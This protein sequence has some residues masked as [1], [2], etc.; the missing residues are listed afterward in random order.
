MT[1]E[2]ITVLKDDTE[3]IDTLLSAINN[4]S[5]IV[6]SQDDLTSVIN[7]IN[8]DLETVT[9]VSETILEEDEIIPTQT[10]LNDTLPYSI[11]IYDTVKDTLI[12]LLSG[13]KFTKSNWMILLNKIMS[14]VS[15]VKKVD[16]KT[17]LVYDLLM[18]YLDNYTDLDDETIDFINAN[19]TFTC[20]Y[21]L[22]NAGKNKK[23]HNLNSKSRIKQYKLYKKDTD[24][25]INTLQIS[26][27]L[28]NKIK[29][30]IRNN[31]ITITTLQQNA[32]EII[33]LCSSFIDKFKHL[34]QQEKCSLISQAIEDVLESEI[35]P[36]IDTEAGK[37]T[38]ELVILNLP[39]LITTVVG[40]INGDIDFDLQN[41]KTFFQRI[42]KKCKK[43][44]SCCCGRK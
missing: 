23:E 40:V 24:N 3:A 10:I 38:L 31:K 20:N 33:S 1:E 15:G 25:M 19:A 34:T 29:I 44:F 41:I 42:K 5:N 7:S 13:M 16:N 43:L 28:I 22:D 36:T 39:M 18:D 6:S 8:E 37:K 17:Q 14:I 27:L 4:A 9:E 30:Y 11:D 26:N 12:S 2:Y 32:P 21:M 35:M